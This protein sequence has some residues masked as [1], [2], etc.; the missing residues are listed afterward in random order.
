[1][2]RKR[3]KIADAGMLKAK[4]SDED[5]MTQETSALITVATSISDYST[6]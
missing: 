1:M 2:K 5:E 4:G 6:G 3:K